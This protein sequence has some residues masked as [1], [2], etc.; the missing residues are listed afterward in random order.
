MAIATAHLLQHEC[1]KKLYGM[2]EK[3]SRW[4]A[5]QKICAAMNEE[6]YPNKK[7][8]VYGAQKIGKTCCIVNSLRS[9][10]VDEIFSLS[11][12]S[13]DQQIQDMI[14]QLSAKGQPEGSRNESL[15]KLL[16]NLKDTTDTANEKEIKLQYL[17]DSLRIVKDILN[18][19]VVLIYRYKTGIVPSIALSLITQH[20]ECMV[21]VERHRL[22]E[23]MET[24]FK[25]VSYNRSQSLTAARSMTLKTQHLSIPPLYASEAIAMVRDETGYNLEKISDEDISNTLIKQI[26]CHPEILMWMCEE[27]KKIEQIFENGTSTIDLIVA[28]LKEKST[29]LKEKIAELISIPFKEEANKDLFEEFFY[30]AKNPMTR[31]AA[32]QGFLWRGLLYENGKDLHVPSKI[33]EYILEHTLQY[34]SMIHAII[35]TLSSERFTS[36]DMNMLINCLGYRRED[37]GGN[38]TNQSDLADNFVK[39]VFNCG[40]EKQLLKEI[41]KMKSDMD[42]LF[43]L[44]L[45]GEL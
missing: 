14:W 32:W 4:D 15:I 12:D 45:T 11:D 35:K 13:Y 24:E 3:G 42:I 9:R 2:E 43:F 21:F 44:N 33:S 30:L 17:Y 40:Q 29:N 36:N 41:K 18:K 23:K 20:I 10:G 22:E 27:I 37:I 6:E 19:P 31:P 39:K 28:A 8:I 38:G 26:G 7:F 5:S 25:G 1:N 16:I 34:P